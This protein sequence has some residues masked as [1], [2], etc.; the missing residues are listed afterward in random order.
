MSKK[1]G[2]N[3]LLLS[4]LGSGGALDGG[5]PLPFTFSMYRLLLAM[6]LDYMQGVIS[7]RTFLIGQLRK[8]IRSKVHQLGR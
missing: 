8:L 6:A 5:L 1:W 7:I 2:V 3:T 4:F